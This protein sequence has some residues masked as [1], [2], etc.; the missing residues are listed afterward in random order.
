MQSGAQKTHSR[1]WQQNEKAQCHGSSSQS[2]N[3]IVQTQ[4]WHAW[5]IQN[6]KSTQW[7]ER[8]ISE[9]RCRRKPLIDHEHCH[10]NT[11]MQTYTHT[12]NATDDQQVRGNMQ[13]LPHAHNKLNVETG[14]KVWCTK[15]QHDRVAMKT[16]NYVINTHIERPK[17]LSSLKR[18]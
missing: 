6:P 12:T 10:Q 1:H 17:R 5:Q 4:S 13:R 8:Q 3:S 16:P 7:F 14:A 2:A 15:K 9:Q 18:E 11:N